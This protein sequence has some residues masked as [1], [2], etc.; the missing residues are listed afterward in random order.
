MNDHPFLQFINLVNLDQKI[1]SFENQKIA[2][3]QQ[4]ALLRKQEDTYAQG[5]D[6]LNKRITQFK[7][8]VDMQELEMGILE[9]KEKEKKKHLENLSDYKNYQALKAEVDDVQ[10]LQ[11]DQ[12]KRVLDAWNQLENAQLNLAKKSSESTQQ[13]EQLHNQM[14]ELGQKRGALDDECAALVEQRASIE[15]GVPAEW[16]EKYILMRARITDPVVPIYHKSCGACSQ[17]ITSQDV[18]RA[19]H[20]ALI[21]CQKCYR[22]LY[23][24]QVMEKHAG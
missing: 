4:I 14:K 9:Q 20:G 19:Q 21:Q 5:L 6:D 10:S 18:I 7:K 3:E 12:E 8:N 13:L 11:V 22:L 16:L 2:V 1:Q 24:P 15:T 17:T 23:D